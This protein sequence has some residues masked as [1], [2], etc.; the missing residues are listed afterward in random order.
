MRQ[1][2]EGGASDPHKYVYKDAKKTYTLCRRWLL[3]LA[4]SP[5]LLSLFMV[6]TGQDRWYGPLGLYMLFPPLVLFTFQ[7]KE[8]INQGVWVYPDKVI[9]ISPK[10]NIVAEISNNHLRK[11]IGIASPNA[12]ATIGLRPMRI[13]SSADEMH[14][15]FGPGIDRY[16]ELIELVQSRIDANLVSNR[17]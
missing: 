7:T 17:N 11:I 1:P 12:W 5:P 10:G 6:A 14:I 13:L 16:A 8:A 3:V 9:E 4:F 15:S 2:A